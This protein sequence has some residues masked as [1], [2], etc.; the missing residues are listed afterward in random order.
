MSPTLNAVETV[1]IPAAELKAAV[2]W[3]A[4]IIAPRPPV[5]ELGGMVVEC[6][7]GALTFEAFDFETSGRIEVAAGGHL[8]RML[9]PGRLLAEATARLSGDVTIAL[10]DG[11]LL[12]R[13]GRARFSVR[14]MPLDLYPTLP[15]PAPPAGRVDGEVL[16]EAVHRAASMVSREESLAHIQCLRIEATDGHLTLWATDRYRAARVRIGW[17]GAD[18]EA[19]VSGAAIESATKGLAGPVALGVSDSL[20]SIAAADRSV[21]VGLYAGHETFPGSL[22]MLFEQAWDASTLTADI[23]DL[24]RALAVAKVTVE[25]K[26]PIQL[27]AT[28]GVIEV[29]SGSD[30]SSSRSAT[31]STG[32]L[33]GGWAFNPEFLS[34]ILRALPGSQVTMRANVTNPAFKPVEF[35]SDG[36]TTFLL[37]PIRS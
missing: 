26:K 16:A 30:R 1:V 8:D 32:D 34:S 2:Q 21:T 35:T 28:P 27:D 3:A 23:D 33:T 10:D 29:S 11:D 19:I 13:D 7:D 5:V 12:L 4:R 37:V 22:P 18:L 31:T 15:D 6:Q 24:D 9:V 17:D 36:D 20:L 25:D 14:T